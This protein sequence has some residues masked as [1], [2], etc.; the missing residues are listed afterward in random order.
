MCVCACVCELFITRHDVVHPQSDFAHS[1]GNCSCLYYYVS[2][3]SAAEVQRS[4]KQQLTKQTNLRLVAVLE[5]P[6][7]SHDLFI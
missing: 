5:L 7:I 3:G 6:V 2:F 1:S 4:W